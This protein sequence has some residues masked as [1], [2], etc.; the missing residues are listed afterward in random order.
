MQEMAPGTHVATASAAYPF[1]PHQRFQPLVTHRFCL[2]CY[3]WPRRGLV[4]LHLAPWWNARSCWRVPPGPVVDQRSS[5]SRYCTSSC[6]SSCTLVAGSPSCEAPGAVLPLA[7]P[8]TSVGASLG[9][10]C[11][12][13]GTGGPGLFARWEQGLPARCEAALAPRV[14]GLLDLCF[15]DL[16]AA[17]RMM[18]FMVVECKACRCPIVGTPDGNIDAKGEALFHSVALLAC[19]LA[20]L[21]SQE[22]RTIAQ[23]CL[24]FRPS[25]HLG[26]IQKP[27]LALNS[28]FFRHGVVQA[29]EGSQNESTHIDK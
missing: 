23:Q 22:F 24:N 27:M 28:S 3:L 16:V 15:L 6:D 1:D 8:L 10:E 29:Y 7:Q 25:L 26:M 2:P 21:G 5:R 13:D 19:L 9:D 20:E 12:L 14:P 11:G 17:R 4:H 18:Y